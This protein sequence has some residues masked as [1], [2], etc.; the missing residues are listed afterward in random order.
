MELMFKDF[1]PKL[2]KEEDNYSTLALTGD[3]IGPKYETFE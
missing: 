2:L 3:V 1:V